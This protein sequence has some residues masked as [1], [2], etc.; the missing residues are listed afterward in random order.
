MTTETVFTKITIDKTYLRNKN[1]MYAIVDQ[2]NIK[3]KHPQLFKKMYDMTYSFTFRMSSSTLKGTV[4]YFNNIDQCMEQSHEYDIVVI[5]NIGNFIRINRFYEV[6]DNYGTNN[7]DFFLMAFTLDWES[8]KRN[9]WVEIHNQMMIVN[10]VSWKKLGSPIF[11][12]WEEVTEELPN[13]TRSEENFHDNYT[14]FWMQGT[15]G[16]SVKTRN[17]PGWGWLKAAFSK[18]IRIDN[19]PQEMRDCRLYVYP[20][21]E[22]ELFYNAL[23]T[24]NTDGL[25][26]P[27]QKK[28]IDRWFNPKPQIWIFNSESYQFEVPTIGS[29]LYF[30]PA[31]GFKYLSMLEKSP[32][33]KFIFYDFNK[34]SI[35]WLKML[36]TSWDGNNLKQFLMKKPIELKRMYKFIN[37]DMDTNIKILHEAFG[38][39]EKFKELW[40]KFRLS[41]AEFVVVDLFD[42]E[43]FKNLLELGNSVT[44][45]FFYYSNIFSTDFTSMKFSLEDLDN[46]FNNFLNSIETRYPKATTFGSNSLGKWIYKR[47]GREMIKL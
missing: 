8:E 15:D 45:P 5:Q 27:N 18:G 7:P 34:E 29:D 12:D 43:Q 46:E 16:T 4:R 40:N 32:D 17:Y 28:L 24:N 25:T 2:D 21:H 39:E 1:I 23:Q 11:G 44:R 37:A 31:S 19:F 13:Y 14:P 6:L 35:E 22:S 47:L 9:G 33:T 30:G 38:G 41:H 36:K 20:V 26:N 42:K 10:V 3:N